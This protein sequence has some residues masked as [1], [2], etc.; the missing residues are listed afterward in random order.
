MPRD[1]GALTGRMTPVQYLVYASAQ[2]GDAQAR[3][4]ARELDEM[5]RLAFNDELTTLNYSAGCF[6][7]NGNLRN[8]TILQ[9]LSD[10]S[11]EDAQGIVNTFNY[12]LAAAI[13]RIG[14]E[15]PQANRY[16]Y[17][18]RLREWRT[19][20]DAWKAPQIVQHTELTAR[21][22]AQSSYRARNAGLLKKARLK[23]TSAKCPVCQGW[24]RR[25]EVPAYVAVRHPPPYHVNC[26]HG[27]EFTSG[28]VAPGECAKLWNGE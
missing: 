23:P 1:P 11:R 18:A 5:R 6:A 15:Y 9:S 26:P 8:P 13:L 7:R 20:R 22:A 2:E 14:E 28:K 24:I 10:E 3:S 17:A 19:T 4:I 27:W 25:G 16:V 21:A 12:D